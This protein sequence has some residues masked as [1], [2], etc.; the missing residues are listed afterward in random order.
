MVMLGLTGGPGIACVFLLVFSANL[1]QGRLFRTSGFGASLV[2]RLMFY[3]LW[4][5]IG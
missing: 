5:I 2:M 4:H 1:V 3:S